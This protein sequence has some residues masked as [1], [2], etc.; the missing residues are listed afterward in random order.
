MSTL[1]QHF[2]LPMCSISSKQHGSICSHVLNG[3]RKSLILLRIVVLEADLKV[4][5]L[6]ELAALA[7]LG[8]LGLLEHLLDALVERLLSHFGTE[9]NEPKINSKIKS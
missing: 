2:R 8:L 1:F 6:Q 7:S 3:S 5:G 4:D 9:M